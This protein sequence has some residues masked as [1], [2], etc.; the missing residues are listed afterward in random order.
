MKITEFEELTDFLYGEYEK[1]SESYGTKRPS[2]ILIE[3]TEKTLLS[4]AKLY[5]KPL[6]RIAKRNLKLQE[7][8]D[9]MPHGF[10][11]KFFH[12]ELW[13]RMQY[14]ENQQKKENDNIPEKQQT[15]P[16]TS[17]PV[18]IVQTVLPPQEFHD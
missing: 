3:G 7:A 15:V 18:E 6:Y 9:T 12:S 4:Y 8:F 11:W 16:N 5:N 1:M 17:L 13:K 14:L 2:K 10:W